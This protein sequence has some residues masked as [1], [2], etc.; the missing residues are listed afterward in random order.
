MARRAD[1]DFEV[2]G[3]RELRTSPLGARLEHQIDA[4][5]R[6]EMIEE[7]L[8]PPEPQLLDTS[9]VQNLDWV[10]RRIASDDPIAWDENAVADLTKR[11]GAEL[12][13]DLIDLGILY[14]EFADR[15]GYP[16]LVSGT[17]QGEASLAGGSKGVGVMSTLEFFR[18]HQD[19]WCDE[20]YPG[21]AKGLLFS[22]RRRRVSPLLLRG[23]GVTSVDEIHSATGPLSFL[24][25]RGDRMVAA[26]A[27][28]S[29]VPVVLTTDRAT[30]WSQRAD[31]V[32]LG[33][34][35]MRPTEL[36]KL[37]EP[38]W[39]ALDEELMRRRKEHR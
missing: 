20:T 34:Q 21:L 7:K 18:G 30:F 9:V 3:N 32:P 39:H 4:A 12:A 28:I 19:D 24:P 5:R 2:A 26:E 27:L 13:D 29:N 1:R 15:G 10:D 14:K 17:V 11:Y 16:W 6:P 31:L 37:Y 25:D 23:L 8:C 22:S 35:V 36:L 33:L 38:Y